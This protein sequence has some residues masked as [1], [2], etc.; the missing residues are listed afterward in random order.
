MQG[1]PARIARGAELVEMDTSLSYKSGAELA[2][3]IKSRQIS[4]IEVVSATLDRIE[5]SQTTL[6]TFITVCADEAMEAARDAEKA[7]MRGDR[8]GPLHG[9]PFS[10][11]DMVET[12]GIRTTFGS[13]A[14]ESN[15][16]SKDAIVITRLRR[17]GAILIGKTTTPEFAAS[18]LTQSPLFGRTRN[19]WRPD[20]TSGGS[21]GGAAVSVAA[22]LCPLAIGTDAGGSTRV[23]A[24]C[25]G[26][27]GFKQSAG[28]IPDDGTPEAFGSLIFITPMT[29]NVGDTALMLDVMSGG[30]PSDPLTLNR[31]NQKFLHSPKRERLDGLRIG[32]RAL[33]GNP[34]ID[35][36]YLELCRDAFATLAQLGAVV[37]EMKDDVSPPLDAWQTIHNSY[38]NARYSKLFDQHRD[39]ITP[40]LVASLDIARGYSAEKFVKA[41][42]ERTAFFRTVQ[43]WFETIDI[44]FTPT[45]SRTALPIDHDPAQSIEIGGKAV[46]PAREAWYPYGWAFNLTG[47]PAV[48][49][50]CGFASDGCPVGIQM[51]GPWGSDRALL[52]VAQ[53][54][55]DVRPW[56]SQRPSLPELDGPEHETDHCPQQTQV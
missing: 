12:K 23:P 9:V 50:P 32:F 2:A 11:K 40:S 56:T 45:I 25:N 53:L 35:A 36:E 31:P 30:H 7:V 54:F 6:N 34:A 1:K 8:L 29:R 24:A 3:L 14:L 33:M 21:S 22:G 26:V 41:G 13:L 5:R 17:A 28:V 42:F 46:G 39:R 19:A 38:R 27:V 51:V 37:T 4:P 49:I 18:F 47:N 10:A 20:R 44:L 15:V 55:E 52:E 48:S 43:G 16:P